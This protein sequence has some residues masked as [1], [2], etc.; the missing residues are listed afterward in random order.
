VNRLCR[1]CGG[2]VGGGW[3]EHRLVGSARCWVLRRH[4]V[5]LC[6]GVG[7]FSGWAIPGLCVGWLVCWWGWGVVVC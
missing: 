6:V 7:V 4:P 3:V 2:G 5:A 1:L